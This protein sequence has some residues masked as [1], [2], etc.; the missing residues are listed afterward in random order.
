MSVYNT[1]NSGEDQGYP[2]YGI[3]YHCGVRSGRDDGVYCGDVFHISI[4][5]LMGGLSKGEFSDCV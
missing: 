5:A 3:S 4:I 1:D 2:E